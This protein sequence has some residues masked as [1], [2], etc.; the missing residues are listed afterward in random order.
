MDQN[1]DSW[2]SELTQ[3]DDI[4]LLSEDRPFGHP[5]EE[6]DKHVVSPVEPTIGNLVLS[7]AR[8][9]PQN[10]LEIGCGSGYLTA[11]LICAGGMNTV[12]AS[13]ASTQFLRLT[14]QK[15]E[16]LPHSSKLRLL[17]LA[18]GELDRIPKDLFDLIIMR[19]VLHHFV[20]FKSAAARLISKLPRDGQCLMLE[21]R[22]DFHI[23]ASLLLKLARANSIRRLSPGRWSK[24]QE[25]AVR[26]FVET[27]EFYLDRQRDKSSAEDKYVFFVEEL[28]EIA[29]DTGTSLSCIGGE[30]DSTYSQCFSDF[31]LY[32][33][34]YSPKV[35]QEITVL[36]S[37]ELA[38][39]D[40]AHSARPR[41]YAAEWFA[42][43]RPGGS[44]TGGL[45][46]IR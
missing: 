6:H 22:A 34:N 36:L 23:T 44:A 21:P 26:N 16:P 14:R 4:Y 17:R 37:D 25:T 15:V 2:L 39:M 33:M 12:V 38:F 8:K 32:C 28:L 18:D 40:R 10:I 5:E 27:A 3:T 31:L 43:T 41:Y 7:H 30:G 45:L 11:S 29:K 19:S 20:D 46:G 9:A 42:V 13:D 1:V 35:V 24:E